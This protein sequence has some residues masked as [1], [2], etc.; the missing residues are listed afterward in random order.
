M[1]VLMNKFFNLIHDLKNRGDI[2]RQEKL[3]I[4]HELK[5][6]LQSLELDLKNR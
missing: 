2:S 5:L 6:E 4:I 1:Y 3:Q